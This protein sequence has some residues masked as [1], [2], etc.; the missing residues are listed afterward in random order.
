MLNQ[1]NPATHL[2]K[3]AERSK[4]TL[5]IG[6]LEYLVT[7]KQPYDALQEYFKRI[8]IKVIVILT[9]SDYK[10][11]VLRLCFQVCY[12][13]MNETKT[14]TVHLL[15]KACTT[16]PRESTAKVLKVTKCVVNHGVV[17]DLVVYGIY[18]T[19]YDNSGASLIYDARSQVA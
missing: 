14:A 4:A 19:F 17:C 8:H 6:N 5:Y 15:K 7:D 18:Y 2:N 3:K 13:V 9:H 12:I 16:Q 11:T 10:L 1:V